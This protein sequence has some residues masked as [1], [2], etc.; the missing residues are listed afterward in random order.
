MATAQG[1]WPADFVVLA[2]GLGAPALAEPLGAVVPLTQKPGT[3][4]ILTQ[5]SSQRL[6][7]R[8]LVTGE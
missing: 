6:L 3:V 2:A 4:N 7:N 1:T 5:P 8:I